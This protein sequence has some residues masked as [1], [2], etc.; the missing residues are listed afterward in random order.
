MPFTKEALIELI[1]ILENNL[2]NNKTTYS[3]VF[4]PY[5]S[6]IRGDGRNL[7]R[8]KLYRILT[9][10]SLLEAKQAI[11]SKQDTE[12]FS[13]TEVSEATLNKALEHCPYMKELATTHQV[14]LTTS[15]L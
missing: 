10:C 6:G 2:D 12:A 14:Q 4:K 3:V 13:L 15:Q 8:I 9:D 11:E 1:I 7:Q 5:F